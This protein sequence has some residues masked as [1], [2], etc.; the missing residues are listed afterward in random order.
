MDLPTI[1]AI[2]FLSWLATAGALLLEHDR[3][4]HLDFRYRYLM[5][6]GTVCVGCL[7]AG[8][9]LGDAL[10]AIVPGLLA[11]SGLSILIKYDSEAQVEREKQTAQKQGEIIGMAR[12]VRRDLTQE[13][14]DRGEN[15]PSRSN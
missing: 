11:T 5:G 4:S 8:V 9:L 1:A 3:W 6:M 2:V 12:R 7:F 14:I 15:D 13:Q 10:L